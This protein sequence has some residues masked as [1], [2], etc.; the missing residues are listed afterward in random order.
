M[1]LGLLAV[2]MNVECGRAVRKGPLM[3]VGGLVGWINPRASKFNMTQGTST[4]S[5]TEYMVISLP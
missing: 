2:I 5:C 3:Q 4:G 1:M